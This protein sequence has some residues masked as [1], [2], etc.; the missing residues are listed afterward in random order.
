LTTRIFPQPGEFRPISV[1]RIR[2]ISDVPVNRC[3][4]SAHSILLPIGETERDSGIFKIIIFSIQWFWFLKIIKIC[5]SWGI[6]AEP[7]MAFNCLK[8]KK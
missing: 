5:D 8:Q 6:S 4:S 2:V 3:L 7:A 1:T